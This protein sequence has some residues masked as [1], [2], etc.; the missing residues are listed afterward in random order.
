MKNDSERR[1]RHDLGHC[2]WERDSESEWRGGVCQ[3]IT[4]SQSWGQLSKNIQTMVGQLND[5]SNQCRCSLFAHPPLTHILCLLSPCHALL[6]SWHLAH[7]FQRVCCIP[8]WC[9][10]CIVRH[11]ESIYSHLWGPKCLA[12][13]LIYST[14][15]VRCDQ[16]MWSSLGTLV[17]LP[18]T[19]LW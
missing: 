10:C 19:W 4:A 12:I 18:S 11:V 7:N 13:S 2:E 15:I 17:S 3:K 8:W 9:S 16:S 1:C 14:C 6:S 5:R